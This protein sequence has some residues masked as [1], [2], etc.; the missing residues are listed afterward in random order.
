MMRRPQVAHKVR[1]TQARC[2]YATLAITRNVKVLYPCGLLA[3]PRRPLFNHHST[4]VD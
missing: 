1:Q 2:V 4:A 3:A